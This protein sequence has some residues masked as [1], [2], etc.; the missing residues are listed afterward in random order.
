M[1]LLR[2]LMQKPWT[3][4]QGP[5]GAVATLP[6]ATIGLRFFLGVV[7]V[8]FFLLTVAYGER[9]SYEEWR[10]LP[11]SWLMWS[12]LFVLVMAS[13]ALQWARVSARRPDMHSVR[14]GLIIGGAFTF[15]FLIGQLWAWQQLSAYNFIATSSPAN[16]FFYLITALHGLHLLG[17]L[18]AWGVTTERVF[19]GAP[20]PKTR[21]AIDLCA[22]YW[23]YLLGIWLLLFVLLFLPGG[24]VPIVC[25]AFTP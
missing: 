1:N 23:H 20:M 17:G 16:A 24:A 9:M 21:L 22:V 8:L 12:N 25:R 11:D 7:T 10:P 5:T 13:V 3:D 19:R 14:R 2:E 15:A 6:S 4:T 18:V